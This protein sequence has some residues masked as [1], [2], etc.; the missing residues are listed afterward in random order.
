MPLTAL[1]AAYMLTLTHPAPVAWANF[2]PQWYLDSY[3]SARESLQNESPVSVLRFYLEKGQTL[4]HSPN[5]LFDE[6]WYLHTYP[7]QA[8]A[9]RA[10]RAASA[11]DIYCRSGFLD[12][13]PHWLFDERPYR[14]CTPISRTGS[15]L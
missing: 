15:W 2:D 5:M 9:V 7:D 14:G 4:G 11:F 12:R 13:S 6:T 10:G 1:P 3:P 8:A